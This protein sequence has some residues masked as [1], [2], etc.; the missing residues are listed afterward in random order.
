MEVMIDASH[1]N[2]ENKVDTTTNVVQE[3]MEAVL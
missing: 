3:R 1:E 2:M